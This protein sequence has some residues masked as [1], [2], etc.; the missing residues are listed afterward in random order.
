MKNNDFKSHL[1]NQSGIAIMMV[2]ASI[3]ILTFIL[4]ELTFE[5]KLNKIK[6]YNYQDK[7]QAR[8]NA[9]AGLRLALAKLRLYQE[10]RNL[11]EKNENL[12]KT[13]PGSAL[14]GAA[15][16][17]FVYPIPVT[18]GANIIQRTAVADF[19]KESLVIGKMTVEMS[20]VSGFLNPNNLRMPNPEEGEESSDNNDSESS[21]DD[22]SNKPPHQYIEDKL[23][24]TLEEAMK[25]KQ[26]SDDTFDAL[27]GNLSASLLVKEMK[28]WVNAPHAFTDPERAELEP[29]YLSKGVT[30]KH[31]PFSSIDELYLLEGWPDQ[32]VD[33]IKDKLTV[34]EVSVIQVNEITKGQ[35]KILFPQISEAQME[36]FFKARDGD[37]EL[38]E[39]GEKFKTAEDFKRL[40]VEELALIQSSEY[41]E[42]M[43][44]FERAGLRIGTAGQLFKVVSIGEFNRAIYKLTAFV[45]IPLK[46]Q[47]K[48]KKKTDNDSDSA[49]NDQDP[50]NDSQDSDK[51]VT[52][53]DKE[54]DKKKKEPDE[55]MVPRVVEIRVD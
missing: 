15:T 4:A 9:E 42:R 54:D 39:K 25:A 14:E 26:E 40:I 11:L 12:K 52:D 10:G 23:V 13:V 31:A 37:Q 49:S 5:T 27:Y 41:D 50:D 1:E 22:E 17:M 20:S 36:E 43:K 38:E 29:I 47:P 16:S 18:K 24:E 34:H 33:L 35:L 53:N 30:P 8:L 48:K 7:L 3:A 51:N 45:E 28:Y 32:I 19:E 6:V 2:M 55:Y 21:D 46:P 44:E